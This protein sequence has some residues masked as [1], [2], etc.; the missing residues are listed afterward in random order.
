[1][2]SFQAI[3][4]KANKVLNYESL[5]EGSLDRD[6]FKEG[7]S[8][9]AAA[10]RY[11]AAD[12]KKKET[13]VIDALPAATQEALRA[14]IHANLERPDPYGI[15]LAWAPATDYE[16]TIWEAAP[17]SVSRGGITVLIKTKVPV[18]GSE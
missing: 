7:E 8:L 9:S 13:D 10:E 2:P 11:G 12:P 17:T 3:V 1:M 14:L 6:H 16:L 15:T 18:P 4:E 5:R